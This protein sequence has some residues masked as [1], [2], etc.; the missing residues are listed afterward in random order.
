M[1]FVG[2]K[3]LRHDNDLRRILLYRYRQF[4]DQCLA[5]G[6][7]VVNAAFA[8]ATKSK[9]HILAAGTLFQQTQQRMLGDAAGNKNHGVGG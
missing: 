1:N 3:R 7:H 4:F 6:K 8:P 5:V 9:H 2:T